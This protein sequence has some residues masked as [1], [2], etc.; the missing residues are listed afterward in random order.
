MRRWTGRIGPIAALALVL[1]ISAAAP[2]AADTTPLVP[3]EDPLAAQQQ[4]LPGSSGADV[5]GVGGGQA[6]GGL[7]NFD[8]SAHTG[9][10]GDFGHVGVKLTSPTG[11]LLVSYWVDVTCVH[12]HGPLLTDQFNRGV[13]KGVVKKVTPVPNVLGVDKGEVLT[14]GIKDGGQPS[15]PTPVD[16]FDAPNIDVLPG[17]SCKLIFYVG[18]FNNVTQGNVTVKLS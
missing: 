17:V 9:P 6:N 11:E 5:Y 1:A 12:I 2:G 4:S 10:N 8:L 14:F 18:N 7:Q 16:D 15:G 3:A 13:I